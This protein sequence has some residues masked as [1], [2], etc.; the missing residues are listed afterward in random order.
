MFY[1]YETIIDFA[2]NTVLWSMLVFLIA[3]FIFRKATEQVLRITGHMFAACG[4]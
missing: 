3:T 1:L 2:W 4:G